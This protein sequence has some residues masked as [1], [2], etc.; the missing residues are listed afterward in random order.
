MK[1]KKIKSNLIFFYIRYTYGS[2]T[3]V[4]MVP[5]LVLVL[6]QNGVMVQL[7]TSNQHK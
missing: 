4:K 6:L 7:L 5:L 1:N 2:T 3:G